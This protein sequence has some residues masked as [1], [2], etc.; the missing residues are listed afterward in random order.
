M[1]YLSV[2]GEPWS[3]VVF[4]SIFGF[5][6]IVLVFTAALLL[7]RWFVDYR[8]TKL[9]AGREDGYRRLLDRYEQ[10]AASTMDAQQRAATDLAE[11]RTRVSSMEQLLRTVDER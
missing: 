8:K 3:D 1:R 4:V 7:I 9:V 5:G 6:T 2:D 10:L 11:L